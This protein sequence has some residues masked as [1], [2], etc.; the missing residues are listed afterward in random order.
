[1]T[2]REA[3][4]PN[5]TGSFAVFHGI[6]LDL[7][8][9]LEAIAAVKERVLPYL[10]IA[11]AK[12]ARG[13]VAELRTMADRFSTWPTLPAE[14]VAQERPVMVGRLLD[15]QRTVEEFTW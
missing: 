8:K 3:P 6:A 9:R 15:V 7:V 2:D 5:R 4:T 14:T 10:D 11:G 12:R 13:L 1:M